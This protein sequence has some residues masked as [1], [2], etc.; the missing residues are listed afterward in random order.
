MR[1]Y[2]EDLAPL[3]LALMAYMLAVSCLDSSVAKAA[4]EQWFRG[5]IARGGSVK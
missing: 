2:W 4:A 3:A 5:M 1:A